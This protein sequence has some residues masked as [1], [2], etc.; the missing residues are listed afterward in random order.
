MHQ[1]LVDGPD[2]PEMVLL[3]VAVA[4]FADAAGMHAAVGQRTLA[5]R[6]RVGLHK[7]HDLVKAA[8]D[9]GWLTV[10]KPGGPRVRSVYNFGPR[11]IGRADLS[12]NGNAARGMSAQPGTYLRGTERSSGTQTSDDVG[13]SRTSALPPKG[14]GRPA[15][16]N[17]RAARTESVPRAELLDINRIDPDAAACPDCHGYRRTINDAGYAI[18][19]S[20]P[21]LT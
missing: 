2:D 5:R 11:L 21:R 4:D 7:V 3:L 17:Q 9:D 15:G 20:H 13:R 19:C 18:D 6:V 10:D 14:G 1:V 16:E 12:T 8:I